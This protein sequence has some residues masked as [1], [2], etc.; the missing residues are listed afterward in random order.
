MQKNQSGMALIAV[1]L[2]LLLIMVAGTIAVRQGLMSLRVATADQ[3]NTLL[4]NSSDSVLANIEQTVESTQKGSTNYVSVF[5]DKGL[6]GYFIN[7]SIPR[8][9]EQVK[10]CYT[11]TIGAFFDLEKSTRMTPDSGTGLIGGDRGICNPSKATDYASGRQTA[12]TQVVLRGMSGNDG[13]TLAD[14]EALAVGEDGR[15]GEG[16]MPRIAMYSVSVLPALS[17]AKSTDIKKCLEYP[18]GA[19]VKQI[20][21]SDQEMT[22]CLKNLGVPTSALVEE[23]MVIKDTTIEAL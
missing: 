7:T 9:N 22:A 23:V 16:Q 8:T 18:I 13:G 3:A 10:R 2:F 12:M 1:L 6:I 19:D 21:N 14:T 17:S 20:Y 5:G 4:L 15:V 11:P